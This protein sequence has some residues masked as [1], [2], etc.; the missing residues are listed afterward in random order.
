[1][2]QDSVYI[3]QPAADSA[4]LRDTVFHSENE[5]VRI[6]PVKYSND[7]QARDGYVF[8][9]SLILLFFLVAVSGWMKL[10]RRRRR[11]EELNSDKHLVYDHLLQSYQPYY[12][13]LPPAMKEKFLQ[14]TLTFMASKEFRYIELQEEEQMP[15]LVSATAVQLTFGLDNYLMN[16]FHTIYLLRDNYHYGLYNVPFEGHVSDDGIYLSWSNFQR[17][18][19]DYSDGQNV[20][21]HEMAHALTYVNFIVHDGM[22]HGFH[23]RFRKFSSIARPIFQRVQNGETTLLDKY[24]STNYDEFWAVCVETFFERPETFRQQLPELYFALVHLLNQDPL[25]RDKFTSI[26][27]NA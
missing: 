11:S 22:D 20:G 18:F 9:I 1:M 24:A 21:L 10:L 16:Y 19:N 25:T 5:P 14:R 2:P 26:P 6:T 13:S 23:D 8:L 4:G 3:Q 12:K 15:L 7:H 27:E 17:E